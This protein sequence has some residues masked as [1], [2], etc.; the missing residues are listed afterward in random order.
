MFTLFRGLHIVFYAHFHTQIA[1][2]PPKNMYSKFFTSWVISK[3][4]PAPTTACHAGPNFLS[5]VS[6][7]ILAAA[8]KML[9]ESGWEI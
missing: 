3:P 1:V 4:N 9:W 8:Y 6:F 5:I 7:I 2:F